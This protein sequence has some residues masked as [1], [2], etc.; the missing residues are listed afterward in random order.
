MLLHVLFKNNYEKGTTK[1]SL[2][3]KQKNE[4]VF[5]YKKKLWSISQSAST[6]HWFQCILK[7]FHLGESIC[8]QTIVHTCQDCIHA[9][10]PFFYYYLTVMIFF[11]WIYFF[12]IQF[13]MNIFRRKKLTRKKKIERKNKQKSRKK[14]KKNLMT[15]KIFFVF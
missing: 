2:H 8:S 12:V 3:L 14:N 15:L 10:I 1:C 5:F 11:F 4:N 7:V 6:S 13:D 9:W